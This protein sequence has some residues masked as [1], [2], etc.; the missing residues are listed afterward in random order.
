MKRGIAK[1]AGW[2]K[3]LSF[4]SGAVCVGLAALCYGISFGQMLLPISVGAKGALWVIF[5]GLAKT[6]Q[7]SAVL[8]LGKSG[9]QRLKGIFAR[10]G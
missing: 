8:I 2:L 9:L 4:R 5:F 1:I 6:F 7:Y 3:G 10:R